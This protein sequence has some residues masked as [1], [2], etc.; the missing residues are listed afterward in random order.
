MFLDAAGS[1]RVRSRFLFILH[2]K[3]VN[4][5]FIPDQPENGA[6]TG[7]CFPVSCEYIDNENQ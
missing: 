1:H 7:I 6:A 5:K 3:R 4:G 2:Y